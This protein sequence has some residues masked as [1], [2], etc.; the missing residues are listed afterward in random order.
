MSDFSYDVEVLLD[1]PTS[2]ENRDIGALNRYSVHLIKSLKQAFEMMGCAVV[3]TRR[4]VHIDIGDKVRT[5]AVGDER[6]AINGPISL[7][8]GRI[9]G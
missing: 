4:N 8:L 6:P 3:G 9:R 2:I 1:L 5:R 7:L